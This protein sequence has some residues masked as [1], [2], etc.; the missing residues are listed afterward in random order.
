[1][2]CAPFAN[3]TGK[4]ADELVFRASRGDDCMSGFPRLFAR[5]TALGELP[6]DIT[7]HVLRH[8]FASLPADLGYSEPTIPA[9]VGHKGQSITSHYIHSADAVR[10]AAADTVA[11]RATELMGDKAKSGVV[12][13]RR[14]AV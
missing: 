14:Q 12:V 6:S 7:P 2:C 9:L 8:S 3:P 11:N 4:K 5:I 10:V 1:M 13:P